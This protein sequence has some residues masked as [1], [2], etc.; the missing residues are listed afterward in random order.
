MTIPKN[1]HDL[2]RITVST[3]KNPRHI[4]SVIDFLKLG[5]RILPRRSIIDAGMG[6]NALPALPAYSLTCKSK[7]ILYSTIFP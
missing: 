3:V 2:S 4:L 5:R 6:L 7:F 1:K